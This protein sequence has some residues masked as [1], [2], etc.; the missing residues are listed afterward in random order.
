LTAQAG[1]PGSFASSGGHGQPGVRPSISPG[2]HCMHAHALHR[3]LFIAVTSGP[4]SVKSPGARDEARA[5]VRDPFRAA[6][7]VCQP[8]QGTR[9]GA[10]C[11]ANRLG[12]RL[13][14]PY[15]A[16]PTSNLLRMLQSDTNV[17]CTA[18]AGTL[19][20][21]FGALSEFTGQAKWR[22][23]AEHAARVGHAGWVSCL[24][25]VWPWCGLIEVLT[26]RGPGHEMT[27][28]RVVPRPRWLP[29]LSHLRPDMGLCRLSSSSARA[30]GWWAAV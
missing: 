21:E 1:E 18:C 25:C 4:A 12:A 6:R 15:L 2:V 29:P 14:C 13:P 11:A 27:R 5:R 10:L 7:A 30:W 26:G 9:R 20:L 3:T 16:C 19:L 24:A 23:L 28:A 22:D 17:T 8:A